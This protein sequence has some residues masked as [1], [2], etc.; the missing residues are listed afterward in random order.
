VSPGIPQQWYTS[1]MP[2][3]YV[4]RRALALQGDRSHN[5]NLLGWEGVLADREHGSTSLRGNANF[6]A[7]LVVVTPARMCVDLA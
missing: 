4:Q 5:S 3:S 1:C 7:D 6:P 2:H